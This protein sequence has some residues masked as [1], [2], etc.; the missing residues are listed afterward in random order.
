VAT[1]KR[2]PIDLIIADQETREVR[3]TPVDIIPIDRQKGSKALA[4]GL[5]GTVHVIV[6]RKGSG[7]IEH[8]RAA[9]RDEK[10]FSRVIAG[11]V[12][13]YRRRKAMLGSAALAKLTV[14]QPVFAELRSS[15]ERLHSGL[16][17]PPGAKAIP[18]VYP[19]NG[20]PLPEK[21]ELVEY[22][23]AGQRQGLEAIALKSPPRL[24]RAEAAALKLAPK[25]QTGRNIGHS[26]DC[27]TTYLLVAALAVAAG[28]LAIAL[29]TG[30]CGVIAQDHLRDD[31]IKRLG[32]GA[33]A[34]R[35]LEMRRKALIKGKAKA[36]ARAR[37]RQH[38]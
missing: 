33:S 37:R 36:R 5:P 17:V 30:T 25:N 34:R 31:M 7:V 38:A 21:L 12:A 9:L 1:E 35:L 26:A 22:V 18:L 23:R 20:G 10:R 4:D 11:I 29:A 2:N 27:E 24:T 19:Y 15:G 3:S 16:F 32:P 28:T 8:L 6:A 13:P 14:R